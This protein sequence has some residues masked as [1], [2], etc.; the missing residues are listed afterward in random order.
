MGSVIAGK[1]LLS[2]GKVYIV[3]EAGATHWGLDS[4]KELVKVAKEAG[5]DAVK[6][7]FVD[8]DRL[9]ADKSVVFRYK[10]LVRTAEGERFEEVEEPLYEILA[11]R[12]LTRQEMK[13]LK[14]FCDSLD[15]PLI[16]TVLYED[17]ADFL[18]DELGVD[19]LKIASAD[20]NHLD[21]IGYCASKGV[22]IQLDTGNADLW[23][24]ERAVIEVERAG[25]RN[26]IIHLCPTGYP[27]RLESINLRMLKTLQDMFP[28]YAIAFS[29]H[30]PGWDMDIAAVA[31]GA[32][33][34]EKTITLDRTIRS[35]EHSFS[36]EPEDAKRFVEVIR[37]VEIALGSSRRIIPP[38]E[39]ERR[40]MGRRSPYALR[41][42]KAGE[43]IRPED[44]EFKRPEAGIRADEFRM[45][46]GAKLKKD[47]R[48]GEC[49]TRE[50]VL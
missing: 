32:K 21:L 36:L 40:R 14:E 46:K 4:A 19:S 42:M 11:R 34:V 28:D 50:H 31:L 49:L 29:D 45:F 5:A 25:N 33:L 1:D 38:E 43:V 20:I 24:I 26:I 13:E 27:A 35:C 10:C 7:Q 12:K 39:K 3:F 15:I 47:I 44:F 48:K 18:V 8:A 17:D 6:F 41:D 22:N 2:S 30:S 9:M 37:E 16:C 23:E